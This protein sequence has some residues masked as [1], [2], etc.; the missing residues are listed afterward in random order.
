MLP[1][2][3][4]AL[5]ASTGLV[6]ET[7]AV[8]ALCP[9]LQQTRLAVSARIGELDVLPGHPWRASYTVVHAPSS[10]KPDVIR[11]ELVD[12]DANVRLRRDLP[13]EGQ[14][15]RD[16]A[17]V[18]A[19]VLDRY[20]R[21][22]RQ[23]TAL[24]GSPDASASG[25]GVDES[26]RRAVPSPPEAATGAPS[27]PQTPDTH[28]TSV[29]PPPRLV[30][31]KTA[32]RRSLWLGAGA[33]WSTPERGLALELATHA[34]LARYFQ[35]GLNVL[36]ATSSDDE[37]VGLGEAHLQTR[38]ARVWLA[39]NNPTEGWTSWAGPEIGLCA[40]H[41]WTTGLAHDGSAWRPRFVFGLAAGT[42]AWLLPHWALTLRAGVDASPRSLTA[43]LAVADRV[44]L[45]QSA[46]Q[47]YATLGVAYTIG[48]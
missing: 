25:P 28:S 32:A 35:L 10:G 27:E 41:G 2:W 42:A 4:A 26:P 15:C 11:L 47:A 20:F 23:G 1:F 5:S 33:G 29:V 6:V 12:P 8:D 30:R 19:L 3:I 45:R 24:E 7:P 46:L 34:E 18:I 16:M 43:E 9:D 39:L 22:L 13:L 36:V 38:A 21:S 31:P 14:S 17:E 40:D 48:R 44:V 37:V